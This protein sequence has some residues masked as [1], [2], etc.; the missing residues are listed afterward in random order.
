MEKNPKT[1]KEEVEEEEEVEEIEEVEE[2][3]DEIG[4]DF[5]KD[6]RAF[7]LWLDAGKIADDALNHVLSLVKP[8][9]SIYDLCIKGDTFIREQ[10]DK[11]Y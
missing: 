9:A 2:E 1:K 3:E 7:A 5:A 4:E 6:P 8:D 10:L 11:I